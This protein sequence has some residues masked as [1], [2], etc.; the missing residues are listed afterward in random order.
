MEVTPPKLEIVRDA[1][2][3][4][5]LTEIELQVVLGTANTRRLSDG[6]FFFMEGTAADKAYILLEGRVRL[7]QVT[8]VGQQVVLGYL[9]PGRVYA[10]IM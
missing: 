5:G 1:A 6:A 4:R 10:K 7:A 8:E 3:L 9:I 2:L